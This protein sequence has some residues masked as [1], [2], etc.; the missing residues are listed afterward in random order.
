ML[1]W[2]LATARLIKKVLRMSESSL[3]ISNHMSVKDKFE[4]YLNIPSFINVSYL[5]RA[6]IGEIIELSENYVSIKK[7]D[8]RV[9]LVRRK[10]ILGVEPMKPEAV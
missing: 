5:D 8:G 9:I 6:I 10:A 4:Q 3:H 7:R 1:V 2:P